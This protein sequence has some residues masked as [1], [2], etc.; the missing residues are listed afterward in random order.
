M[1]K[2]VDLLKLSSN[3]NSN[4]MISRRLWYDGDIFDPITSQTIAPDLY[5]TFNF[6]V[7]IW[8]S[9]KDY[10]TFFDMK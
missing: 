8:E 5:Y 2:L 1:N 6:R 9:S 10:S 3:I 7:F 4:I